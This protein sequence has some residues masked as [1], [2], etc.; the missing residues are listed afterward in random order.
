[1]KFWSAALG[2]PADDTLIKA[3]SSGFLG[4]LPRLT[5]RMVRKHR[6][7]SLATAKGHMDRQRQ[8][9]RSTKIKT[10]SVAVNRHEYLDDIDWDD[11]LYT[12]VA[13]RTNQENHSELFGKF[14]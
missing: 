4:N 10:K 2:S 1:M 11:K 13:H 14:L 9:V 12:L 8:G 5:A 3:L 6:P 7:N